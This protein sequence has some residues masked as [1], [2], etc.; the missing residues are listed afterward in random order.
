MNGKIYV[1]IVNKGNDTVFENYKIKLFEDSNFN[2]KFDETDLVIGFT[3]IASGHEKGQ[4][5]TA[6]IDVDYHSKFYKNLIWVVV[7]VNNDV[8]ESNE[9]NNITN[10][11]LS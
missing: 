3:N 2:E 7:D 6:E 10:D 8:L 1:D 11:N 9:E 5:I 4:T